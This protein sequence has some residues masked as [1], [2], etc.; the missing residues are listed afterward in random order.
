MYTG[1]HQNATGEAGCCFHCIVYGLL[2]GSVVQI[3]IPF[4]NRSSKIRSTTGIIHDC[5][6]RLRS[7]CAH[8]IISNPPAGCPVVAWEGEVSKVAVRGGVYLD[9]HTATHPATNLRMYM[10]LPICH[11]ATSLSFA[12]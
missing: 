8:A 10:P 12:M 11:Y 5:D 1:V 2:V 4:S 6:P 3:L 7:V 9:L